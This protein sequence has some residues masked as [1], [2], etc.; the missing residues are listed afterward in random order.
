MPPP[1]LHYW[2]DALVAWSLG[3]KDYEKLLDD[4]EIDA[5]SEA[6]RFAP[7]SKAAKAIENVKK[8][9]PALIGKLQIGEDDLLLIAADAIEGSLHGG[10]GGRIDGDEL[11]RFFGSL[12]EFLK[13]G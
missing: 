10:A 6:Q 3:R 4:D 5:V 8:E 12:E 13:Q 2:L 11:W 1:P 9:Y 7:D